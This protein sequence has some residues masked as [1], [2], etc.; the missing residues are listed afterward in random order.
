MKT[1]DPPETDEMDDMEDG[2]EREQFR[3]GCRLCC[4]MDTTEYGEPCG[5][6]QVGAHQG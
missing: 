4:C 5:N 1:V 3:C 2:C 6:C